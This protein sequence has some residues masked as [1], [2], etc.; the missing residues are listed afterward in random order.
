M[1][2]PRRVHYSCLLKLGEILLRLLVVQVLQNLERMYHRTLE[3]CGK[4]TYGDELGDV[5]LLRILLGG[6]FESVP[7]IPD[8]KRN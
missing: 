6:A 7:S 1:G 2:W 3:Q 8:R 5:D 4:G